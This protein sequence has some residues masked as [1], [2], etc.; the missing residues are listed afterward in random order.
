YELPNAGGS[1]IY[2][3]AVS[4]VLLMLAGVWKGFRMKYSVR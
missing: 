3:Y 2:W 1:G 4:G